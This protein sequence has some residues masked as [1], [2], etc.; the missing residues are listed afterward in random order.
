MNTGKNDV[1]MKRGIFASAFAVSALALA[2][3]LTQG[4]NDAASAHVR[5]EDKALQKYK[6]AV[7][8]TKGPHGLCCDL[9][10]VRGNLKEKIVKDETG[11]HYYVQIAE[12]DEGEPL[13]E[14][15]Q[16]IKI[17]DERVLSAKDIKKACDELPANDPDKTTCKVPNTNILW[18]VVS[19]RLK[20]MMG[21]Q[22]LPAPEIRRSD[23]VRPPYKT[24]H[25]VFCYFPKPAVG[26]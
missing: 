5:E 22:T 26:Q 13:L 6:G 10:D 19:D 7:L 9:R 12:D 3:M 18:G 17:P 11:L 16:W 20:N 8:K 15:P 23:S 1:G 25:V 2:M 24:P 14:G 4:F 21:A